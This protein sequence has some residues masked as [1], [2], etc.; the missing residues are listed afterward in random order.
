M[1]RLDQLDDL[2]NGNS[3][4]FKHAKWKVLFSDDFR[5]TFR[6]LIGSGLENQVLNLLLKHSSGWRPNIRSI[7]L[8]CE[9]SS[10]I[11][12]QFK[13]QGNLDAP[14]SWSASQKIIR[15]RYLI[16]DESEVSVNPG[17]ARN[18]VENS[19]VGESLLLM[20]FYSLSHEVISHLLTGTEK[21]TLLTMKLFQNEHKFRVASDGI[22]E[23]EISQF[24]D[25]E[26]VDDVGYSVLFQLFLLS[27]DCLTAVNGGVMV[28]SVGRCR[29]GL[30]VKITGVTGDKH[31]C[32]G[33]VSSGQKKK[34][35]GCSDVSC[36]CV[37]NGRKGSVKAGGFGFGSLA[38]ERKRYKRV[39]L[40]SWSVERPLGTS[41]IGK[42]YG[43]QD[44]TKSSKLSV[45]RS[46]F[47][48][49]SPNLCYAVKQNVSN[50]TSVSSNGSSSAEINLGNTD[51]ILSEFNDIPD[52]F[53]NIPLKYYPLV[54][55]YQKFLM[56]LDGTL[57]D[58]F[59][60]RFEAREDS[61]NNLTS[62]R[63][64]AMQSVIRLKEVTFDKFCSFYWPHF[65]SN[66]TKK[67][68]GSIVFTEII[69][70]I[71]GGVQTGE[72]IHRKLSYKG[73]CL[74]AESR[75][76]TL[77]KEKREIVY[78]L[79]E[80]YEKMKSERG[81]YDLGDLVNDI[82]HRLKNRKYKGDQMDFVYIDEVQDLSMRQT[83]LFKYIFQNVDEGFIFAGDT[84]RGVDFRFQ[85]VRFIF[86]KEF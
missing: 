60:E 53:I 39:T 43:C 51:V 66:L 22:C 4:L 14:R 19:K 64:I 34:V 12:K 62:S 11:L 77:N 84:A 15:F 56:M 33:T 29:G 73:Y 49:A 8:C 42:R 48:T 25:A 65:N 26:V 30:P 3:L 75:T 72:C 5:R 63:S 23:A 68:D 40:F 24:R 70:H 41:L 85:D 10:Q 21:T 46:F 7:D 61:H 1:K 79:F 71:K 78:I 2:V 82:H 27:S 17:H 59:F 13:V 83:S 31:L 86:Y 76:S 52:T 81:E 58:S 16:E 67:L 6:K 18:Y 37:K 28:F 57:G 36:G 20:K 32:S 47:V 45:L 44:D 50:I 55:T 54:I 80:A 9:N 38:V 69:S 35:Q 74:L